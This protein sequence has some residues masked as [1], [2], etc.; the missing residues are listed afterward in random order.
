MSLPVFRQARSAASLVVRCRWPTAQPLPGLTVVNNLLGVL[1]A[2]VLFLIY[3]L[4]AR[5]SLAWEA[6][7]EKRAGQPAAID[8]A[9]RP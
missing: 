9:A 7:Q 1:L 8:G 2:T 3:C 6:H 5:L 4:A